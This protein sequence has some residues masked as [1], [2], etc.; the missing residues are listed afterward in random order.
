MATTSRGW[1]PVATGLVTT[2]L[3]LWVAAAVS[4]PEPDSATS[5][6]PVA[7][8]ETTLPTTP[9][10]VVA[11]DRVVITTP[12]PDMEG[13]TESIARVLSTSGFASSLSEDD[14]AAQLPGSIYRT[15]VDQGVVLSIATE[16][17]G[18]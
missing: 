8:A 15:L 17:P 11:P 18:R 3:A 12:P 1:L 14:I 13:L 7:V 2:G 6:A 16:D 10:T 9:A 5:V 4:S